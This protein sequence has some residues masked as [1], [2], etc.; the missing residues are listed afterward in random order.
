MAKYLVRASYTR[1]GVQG[2]LTEGATSRRAAVEQM[3]QRADG[4]LETFYYALG[5]TDVFAIVDVPDSTTVA[6]I[7]LA[8]NAAGAVTLSSTPLLTAAEIDEACKRA[9]DY[10]PPGV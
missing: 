5:E 8:V 1:D 3:V 7:S 4:T 2:L 9:V 6:A 10:R